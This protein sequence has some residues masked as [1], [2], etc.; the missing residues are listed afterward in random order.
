MS[1]NNSVIFDENY[2]KKLVESEKKSVSQRFIEDNIGLIKQCFENNISRL[3]LYKNLT[4]DG[5]IDNSYTNFCFHID[6]FFIFD[7]KKR[8]KGLRSD[9]K[10]SAEL[11]EKPEQVEQE[12]SQDTTEKYQENGDEKEK[13]EGVTVRNKPLTRK[14]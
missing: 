4:S 7:S 12:P 13:N 2:V 8:Y 11:Q 1:E 9:Q 6:K 5:L 14:V 10:K 3:R